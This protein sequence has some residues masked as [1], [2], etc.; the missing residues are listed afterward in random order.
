M[1]ITRLY[2]KKIDDRAII[3]TQRKGDV[4]LDVRCIEDII[5]PPGKMLKLRTGLQLARSPESS[6]GPV[7]LKVED[8]SSMALKGITTHGGVIDPN[9][10]GEFHVI[11]FNSTDQSY[12]VKSGDKVAQLIVY[13]AAFNFQM[14]YLTCE[15]V[16]EVEESNR[17]SGGFGSTGR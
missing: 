3:P 14:S 6:F 13:P 16:D 15:E 2:F 10:R 9:Y 1:S 11:L 5:I 7:F 12:E 8:R 4:G 17:G